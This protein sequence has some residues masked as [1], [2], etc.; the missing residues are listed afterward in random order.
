MMRDENNRPSALFTLDSENEGAMRFVLSV[1]LRDEV[2]VLGF[3][4]V[5]SQSGAH[6]HEM[7][8]VPI[9]YLP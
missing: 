9:A 3:L 8:A 2:T 7:M 6:G 4:P 1:P 5:F